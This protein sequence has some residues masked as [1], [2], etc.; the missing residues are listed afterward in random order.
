MNIYLGDHFDAFVR[1]QVATGRYAN[2]SEVVRE[3][4]RMY[5]DNLV[6]RAQL[7]AMIQEGLDD[8][9]AGRVVEWTPTLMDEIVQRARQR[10][11]TGE[12]S[13]HEDGIWPKA[14]LFRKVAE[15]SGSYS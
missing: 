7:Q 2:A 12:A 6:G 4:L 10:I 15:G 8:I 5:E 13:E 14:D 11:E 1:E 3:A 9:E